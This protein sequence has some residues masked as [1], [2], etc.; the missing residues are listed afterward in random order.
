MRLSLALLGL[1]ILA[2]RFRQPFVR[3]FVIASLLV[4]VGF[5]AAGLRTQFVQEPMLHKTLYNKTVSGTVENIEVRPKG[6]RL[7]LTAL[8]IEEVREKS[9][10]ERVTVSLKEAVPTLKIG[11]R[12]RARAVLFPLP[13]PV[14]PGGY[15]FARG[16]FFEG[17]G[18]TGYAPKPPEVIES[19]EI[20][21]WKLWLNDLRLHVAERI[22]AGM[23]TD[24]GAVAAALMVGEESGVSEVVKDAMRD[25]GIYHVLSISGLH[26]SIAVGLVY[27]TVRFLLSLYM[28]LALKLPVKKIS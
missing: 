19:T 25:A 5:S 3:L 21:G 1:N 27:M 24:S 13:T 26:M 4:T 20:K 10:P 17:I 23:E 16:F 15:D 22:R 28:P 8:E 14:I 12:I 18:A 11:D 6:Q 7:T 9:T 2:L